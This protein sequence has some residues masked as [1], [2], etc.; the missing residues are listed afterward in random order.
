MGSDS[1]TENRWL[2]L[3]GGYDG[4]LW[5]E[6][7]VWPPEDS[8]TIVILCGKVHGRWPS[9]QLLL[10]ELY[11]NGADGGSWIGDVLC[12][13]LSKVMHTDLLDCLCTSRNFELMGDFT[14]QLC[15][16][17]D[18]WLI[19]NWLNYGSAL[20]NSHQWGWELNIFYSL[21]WTIIMHILTLLLG[22]SMFLIR[23]F[24]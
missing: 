4:R 3:A 13:A 8:G 19:Y 21:K 22:V 24:F 7:S 23:K 15:H 18:P 6:C 10:K 2:H 9:H 5:P 20:W 14:V 12:G 1:D 11:D 17:K 16:G